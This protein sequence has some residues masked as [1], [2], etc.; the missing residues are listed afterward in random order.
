V[1]HLVSGLIQNCTNENGV[2][3]SLLAECFLFGGGVA[4]QRVFGFGVFGFLGQWFGRVFG[5]FV[6]VLWF[7]VLG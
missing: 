5:P 7:R 1:S 3:I 6:S 4:L 2:R